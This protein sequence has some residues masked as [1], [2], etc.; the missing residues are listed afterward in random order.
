MG[1][2]YLPVHFNRGPRDSQKVAGNSIGHREMK[3]YLGIRELTWDL[4][5]C[6]HTAAPAAPAGLSQ[7]AKPQGGHLRVLKPLLARLH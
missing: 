4:Y 6:G 7:H 3:Q 2:F 1:S 5:V